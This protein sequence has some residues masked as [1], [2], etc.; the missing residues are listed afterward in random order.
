M[1]VPKRIELFSILTILIIVSTACNTNRWKPDVS[2]IKADVHIK[3]FDQALFSIDTTTLENFDKGI[4]D[5]QKQYP[6]IYEAYVE[7]LLQIGPKDSLHTTLVLKKLVADKYWRELYND[8]QKKY[9]D[10]TI[11]SLEEQFSEAFKY[12]K[13]YYPKDTL[14]DV[15]AIV[16]GFNPYNV[17]P[18]MF[19]YE[20]HLAVSLEM[21]MGYNY[22]FYQ[23]WPIYG[24]YQIKRFDKAY[25]LPQALKLIFEERYP[26]EKYTD[27]TLL[28]KAIYDGK[29]LFFLSA[30]APEMADTLKIEYTKAQLDWIEKNQPQMWNHFVSNNLLYSTD[31]HKLETYINDAPFTNAEQVPTEAPP[32][33]GTFLGWQIVKK[34]VEENPEKSLQ[35]ILNEKDYRKILADSKYRPK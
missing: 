11:K 32:R 24:D 4:I 31:Q 33:L 35:E 21:Y 10:E 18:A 9:D 29:E 6:E 19:T 12:L 3:R 30:M 25:I 27:G 1:K 5:L 8:V 17:V 7:H 20:N 14:P 28:S 23:G 26:P 16:K 34:Y 2:N 15:V 13:Y 22:K